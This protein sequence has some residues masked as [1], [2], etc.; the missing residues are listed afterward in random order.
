MGPKRHDR[1]RFLQAGSRL[2]AL[3]L[4]APYFVSSRALAAPGR[5]GANDRLAIG[6]IG[7]GIRGK[8]LI[9]N[10]PEEGRVV[11]ICD[12]YLPRVAD[13]LQPKGR[14]KGMLARFREQDAERCTGY[15]DFR[16]LLDGEKLD[17][18]MIATPDHNHILPAIL[19]CQAG[20]DVYCEKAL[21][22]YVAEG[23]ALE[24]VAKR[25]GRV[26]GERPE[27]SGGSEGSA[28]TQQWGSGTKWSEGVGSSCAA[29]PQGATLRHEA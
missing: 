24:G 20:L 10:M 7:T 8:Y 29:Q 21:S 13:T 14:Y 22:L 11:A 9:A 23:R 5:R 17:A 16:K 28:R 15:Q 12:S 26:R 18:V 4:A 3:G 6:V 25:C 1:R 2:T 19:A 27:R